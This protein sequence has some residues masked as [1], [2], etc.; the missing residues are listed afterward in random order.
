MD[1][2]VFAKIHF[3]FRLSILKYSCIS[4]RWLVSD[5]AEM[6]Q[7]LTRQV[8]IKCIGIFT[9]EAPIC[10]MKFVGGQNLFPYV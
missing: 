1:D 10:A 2:D 3:R 9:L 5:D 4:L 6:K 8:E 7:E